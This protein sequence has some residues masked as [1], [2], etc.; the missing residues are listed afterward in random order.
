MGEKMI[1][2]KYRN[3]GCGWLNHGHD[4]VISLTNITTEE[5][6]MLKQFKKEEKEKILKECFQHPERFL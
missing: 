1:E 6:D 4:K 5:F 3:F 2:R